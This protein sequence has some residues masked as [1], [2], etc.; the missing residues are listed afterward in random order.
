MI[1]VGILMLG[2]KPREYSF[3]LDMLG[4]GSLRARIFHVIL[5]CFCLR[6]VPNTN[7]ISGGIQAKDLILYST[8]RR[9]HW[10]WVLPFGGIG[11]LCHA[12]REDGTWQGPS[13]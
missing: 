10:P 13:C 5:S 7:G 12:V 1:S 3:A 8:A 2:C 6:W 9:N 4:F 11:V